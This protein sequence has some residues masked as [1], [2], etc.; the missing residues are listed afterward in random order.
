M[1]ARLI[2]ILL[3]PYFGWSDHLSWNDILI[4]RN[5]LMHRFVTIDLFKIPANQSGSQRIIDIRYIWMLWFISFKIR[6]YTEVCARLTLYNFSDFLAMVTPENR[7]YN[8]VTRSWFFIFFSRSRPPIWVPF[9]DQWEFL[10]RGAKRLRINSSS[11]RPSLKI[12]EDAS[13]ISRWHDLKAF[14]SVPYFWIAHL[15]LRELLTNRMTYWKTEK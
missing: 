2:M 8:N 6:Y 13:I 12:V 10:G 4:K 5:K 7:G 3:L 15:K 1:K 11:T 9:H 14:D